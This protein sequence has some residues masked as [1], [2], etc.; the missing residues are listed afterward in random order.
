MDDKIYYNYIFMLSFS[1]SEIGC[2]MEVDV[3]LF[4]FSLNCFGMYIF[5]FEICFLL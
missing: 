3:K 2:T 1:I 5:Y 4:I